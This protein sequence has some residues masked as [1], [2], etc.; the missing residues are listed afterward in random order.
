[1]ARRQKKSSND[2]GGAPGW[3]VT[4][5]DLMSL[6]LTFFVLILSFA[7][8]DASKFK[9]VM[10]SIKMAFGV[11]KQQVHEFVETTSNPFEDKANGK[12]SK[13]IINT[14]MN[15]HVLNVNANELCGI[16]EKNKLI[17]E[18]R[19]ESERY[20]LH[21]R[22]TSEA[23]LTK[24]FSILLD[25][26][27][28]RLRVGLKPNA[29]FY[30]DSTKIKKERIEDLSYLFSK[31]GDEKL[32]IAITNHADSLKSSKNFNNWKLSSGRSLVLAYISQRFPQ[33]KKHKITVNSE[34]IK[35]DASL[36][37]IEFNIQF[38]KEFLE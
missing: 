19:A 25:T 2:G 5:A 15:D 37:E 14:K 36:E 32:K 16:E 31:L 3:I 27:N 34:M 12:D 30:K 9:R 17:A 24:Y 20:D 23:R 38:D 8:I 29:F 35:L 1:M 13:K 11:Q 28:K 21:K 4:F 26:D 6:L 33:S 7:E 10:G 18:E 22:L